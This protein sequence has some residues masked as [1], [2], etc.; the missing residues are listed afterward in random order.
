MVIFEFHVFA[1]VGTIKPETLAKPDSR[2]FGERNF[3]KLL[4]KALILLYIVA[5]L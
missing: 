1:P 2:N 4:A 3:G 5:L